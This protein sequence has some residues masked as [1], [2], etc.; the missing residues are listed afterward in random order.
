MPTHDH[1][2]FALSGQDMQI[3]LTFAF[4][5]DEMSKSDINNKTL[6]IYNQG[7]QTNSSRASSS[8]GAVKAEKATSDATAALNEV[9]D[10]FK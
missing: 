10:M 9:S 1:K 5:L 8:K 7:K 2:F 3:P 4:L 6:E